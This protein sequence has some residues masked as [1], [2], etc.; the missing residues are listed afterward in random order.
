[1]G[2]V[3]ILHVAESLLSLLISHLHPRKEGKEK[4]RKAFQFYLLFQGKYVS[5]EVI[6][7]EIF[8]KY[9][10]WY[11]AGSVWILKQSINKEHLKKVLIESISIF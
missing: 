2:A 3:F 5:L 7:N 4:S 10:N 9:I 8:T 1:V 11:S 6:F